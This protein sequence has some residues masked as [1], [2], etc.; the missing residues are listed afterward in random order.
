[1]PSMPSEVVTRASTCQF[2]STA[3]PP[4]VYGR[5]TGTRTT[6]TAT[7]EIFIA[8]SERED[9][10]AD[11]VALVVGVRP[12]FRL[13]AP[14]VRRVVPELRHRQGGVLDLVGAE[15]ARL[16]GVRRAVANGVDR[17]R[18]LEQERQVLV[19]V[20]VVEESLAM[21]LDVH[22]HPEHIGRLAR[23]RGVAADPLVLGQ[24]PVHGVRADVAGPPAGFAGLLPRGAIH[25]GERV[26]L[27]GR[28]VPRLRR[29][30]LPIASGPANAGHPAKIRRVLPVVDLV[31]RRFVVVRDIHPDQEQRV[32]AHENPPWR[33]SIAHMARVGAALVALALLAAATAQAQELEPRAYT[34][35]PVGMN[36]LVLGYAFTKGD[37][38]L[39][40]SVPIEDGEIGGAQ[41]VSR[42]RPLAGCLG[43]C[44]QAT[45]R[46][47]VR[48]ALRVRQ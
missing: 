18:Q 36:F 39:D 1:M 48:L 19:V 47:A 14:D 9:A 17:A 28:D 21:T 40:T 12:H 13:P 38:A 34:N 25:D 27:V 15:I 7:C 32:S 41:R 24:V 42:V 5:S 29:R 3:R 37:V 44:G 43:S 2:A 35:T 33:A 22:H 10:L 30:R 6:S 31:E 46:A 4:A 45:A 26:E 11:D 8:A 23:E 20:E 16:G